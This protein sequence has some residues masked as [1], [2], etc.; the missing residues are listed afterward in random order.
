MSATM[1]TKLFAKCK[2]FDI[3]GLFGTMFTM[4]IASM[5]R[6]DGA[7]LCGSEMAGPSTMVDS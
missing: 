6:T 3:S 1:S 7:S 4:H 5:I 2:A